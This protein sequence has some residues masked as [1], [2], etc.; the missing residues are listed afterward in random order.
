MF[1]K[2]TLFFPHLYFINEDLQ[3]SLKEFYNLLTQKIQD[4]KLQ[5]V[6]ISQVFHKKGGSIL[7]NCD[8]YFR[9][10]KTGGQFLNRR[11]SSGLALS[12]IFRV[13]LC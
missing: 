1:K 6:S 3:Q 13:I 10:L 9:F 8:I 4:R 12:N 11:L 5:I 7:A 2:D